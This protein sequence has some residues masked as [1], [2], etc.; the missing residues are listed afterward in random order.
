MLALIHPSSLVRHLQKQ[1]HFSK[2]DLCILVGVFHLR[3]LYVYY[4]GTQ[5]KDLKLIEVDYI[6]SLMD[7]FLYGA[8]ILLFYLIRI[9]KRDFLRE[10][11][12]ISFGGIFYRVLT[13]SLLILVVYHILDAREFSSADESIINVISWT[14]YF[15]YLVYSSNKLNH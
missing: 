14:A 6:L 12:Y 1:R 13:M 15:Y 9:D 5:L 8:S 7:Y 11:L 4:V 10:F 2:L 3:L